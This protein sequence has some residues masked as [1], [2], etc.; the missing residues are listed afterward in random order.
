MQ[1]GGKEARASSLTDTHGTVTDLV[2]KTEKNEA[3]ED[4]SEDPVN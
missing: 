3:E 4:Q 1:G 2:Y